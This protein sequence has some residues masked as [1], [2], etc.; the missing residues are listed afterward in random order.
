MYCLTKPTNR[1]RPTEYV[2]AKSLLKHSVFILGWK[3]I[4]LAPWGKTREWH[5]RYLHLGGRRRTYLESKRNIQ[6]Y[7]W[8]GWE[9]NYSNGFLVAQWSV[10]CM[11]RLPNN[12]YGQ[13]RCPE[14]GIIIWIIMLWIELTVVIYHNSIST[15][16]ANDVTSWVYKKPRC[17][18]RSPLVKT[19]NWSVE[20]LGR[21]CN[22]TGL[23]IH[24]NKTRVTSGTWLI[25]YL[26][27]V[28]V[29]TLYLDWL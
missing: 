10:Q 19:L 21:A 29:Q 9:G 3:I 18:F 8:R 6:G 4:L 15:L 25:L 17:D 26:V 14:R 2:C 22:S 23:C 24:F 12:R 28:N 16:L 20:M 1:C 13:R 11:C 27:A 7:F 5:S